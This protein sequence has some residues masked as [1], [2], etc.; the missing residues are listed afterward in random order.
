MTDAGEEGGVGVPAVDD[1]GFA[2]PVGGDGEGGAFEPFGGRAGDGAVEGDVLMEGAAN[3]GP[4]V[5][6]VALVGPVDGGF[7]EAAF[8]AGG[9]VVFEGVDFVS[10]A[11]QVG[12]VELGVVDVP[13]EAGEFPDEQ[14]CHLESV[15]EVVD[16]LLEGGAVVGVGGGAGIPVNAEDGEVVFQRPLDDFDFLLLDGEFLFFVAGITQVDDDDC[17]R[18][19][20]VL[21]LEQ[22]GDDLEKQG[23]ASEDDEVAQEFGDEFEEEDDVG[24]FFVG[25]GGRWGGVHGVP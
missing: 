11:A 24:D 17:A 22:D 8:G 13:G 1:A 12:F 9:D 21:H 2:V 7:K 5:F 25:G 10:P 15:A 20:G 14:A 23:D 19:E 4:H 3:V 6:D 18:G 16:E